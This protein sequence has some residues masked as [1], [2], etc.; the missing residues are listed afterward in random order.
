MPSILPSTSAT[1]TVGNVANALGNATKNMG[2]FR[3][4]GGSIPTGTAPIS[5]SQCQK[6][7]SGVGYYNTWQTPNGVASNR[8]SWDDASI[9]NHASMTCS[10]WFKSTVLTANWRN[11]Y[12]VAPA[13]YTDV[14]R[15]PSVYIRAGASDFHIRHDTTTGLNQGIDSTATFSHNGTRYHLLITYNGTSLKVYLNGALTQTVTQAGTPTPGP[16]YSVYSPDSSFPYTSGTLNYL[17]FF[18]YPMTDAQVLTY[19]NSL[20]SIVV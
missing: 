13:S 7:Q 18:P 1:I 3:G 10:V 9:T 15:R 8:G 5:M 4:F 12:H 17:W 20:T 16:G 2:G 6:I 11:M 14:Y 19:Y